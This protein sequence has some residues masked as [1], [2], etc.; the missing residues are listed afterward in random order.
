MASAVTAIA[1]AGGKVEVIID[2]Q[3][4]E[5]AADLQVRQPTQRLSFAW[6]ADGRRHW[7][8]VNVRGPD[9]KLW[10]LGNPVY[11]EPE[12]SRTSGAASASETKESL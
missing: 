11:L 12:D 3:Q 4:H 5:V 2:G 8:R 1:S 7:L 9:G 6:T 10:L